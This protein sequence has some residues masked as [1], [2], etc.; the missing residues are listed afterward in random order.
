MLSEWDMSGRR[1]RCTDTV[2]LLVCNTR[3][4]ELI[5]AD[6]ATCNCRLSNVKSCH[7]DCIGNYVRNMHEQTQ[8][9][10]TRA[11]IYL[12]PRP[13]Q[14]KIVK[15]IEEHKSHKPG[16]KSKKYLTR[17]PKINHSR[18][19]VKVNT[20]S[21]SSSPTSSTSQNPGQASHKHNNAHA[22]AR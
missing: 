13:R 8:N 11:F 22:D 17:R 18:S 19:K 3:N 16:S 14:S 6:I 9:S 2:D 1:C 7:S 15:K 20:P 10:H 5:E 4:E 21:C 12:I